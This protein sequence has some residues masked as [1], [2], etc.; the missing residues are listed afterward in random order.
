MFRRLGQFKRTLF[1]AALWLVKPGCYCDNLGM[2]SGNLVL[3]IAASVS[4][5]GGVFLL[6]S[7]TLP[8]GDKHLLVA[9]IEHPQITETS[10]YQPPPRMQTSVAMGT[11]SSS[12]STLD[13]VPLFVDRSS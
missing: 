4:I 1:C 8:P 13:V 3:R 7:T 12:I 9:H 2:K 11:S 10:Q 6:A 5:A